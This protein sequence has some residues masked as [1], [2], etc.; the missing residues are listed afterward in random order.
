MRKLSTLAMLCALGSGASAQVVLN[1][2]FENPPGGND[3]FW[4]YIEF[5]GP[6]GMSLDGYAVALVKGGNDPNA[7]GVPE[8]PSEIDEAFSLDGLALGVN[9][10]LVL[11]NDT[12]GGSFAFDYVDAGT[13]VAYF[14]QQHIAT[15]DTPGKL[16]NDDSSTYVLLRKRPVD[17]S[18]GFTTA[19]RKDIDPDENWDSHIDFGPPHQGYGRVLEPYQMV[20]NFA[21]SNN[22]GKEYVRDSQDEVSNTPGFNPDAASRAAYYGVNPGP[23]DRRADEEWVYG[24]CLV[25]NILQYDIARSGGPTGFDRT[26]YLLTPGGFNDSANEAQF[27]FTPGDVDFDGRATGADFCAAAALLGATLDDTEPRVSDNETP[28]D[29]SDDFTFDAWKYEGRAFNSLLVVLNAD[30]NNGGVVQLADLADLRSLLCLGDW[31]GDGVTNTQDVLAYLNAWS[32]SSLCADINLDG[33]VN[34]IDFLA[35]LNAWAGG[36]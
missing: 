17:N 12:G 20:D 22:G 13:T 18:G 9:G 6:A 1:E 4:E 19:W 5:Y 28:D 30:P 8:L 7:D 10:L 21:W 24:D 32:S 16:G 31:N 36:C 14:S 26:E 25:S 33:A 3:E 11:L 27:R 35:F 34:T 15:T 29:E 23:Q 2:A